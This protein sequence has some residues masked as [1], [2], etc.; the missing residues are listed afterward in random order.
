MIFILLNNSYSRHLLLTTFLHLIFSGVE[1]IY[2][3]V[4]VSAVQH[5][6]SATRACL[7]AQLCPTLRPRG[8]QPTSLLCPWDAPGKD[9]GVGCQALLQEIFLTQ[10]LN[11][12]LPHCRRILYHL[13]R[14]GS[15]RISSPYTNNS[16]FSV[17]FPSF[18][19]QRTE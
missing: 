2:N 10:G 13:S 15:P 11:P 8:L 16:C 9:T 19:P 3:T 7:V 6:E 18:P 1:L 12:G 17:S 14:Q 5:C 4:S